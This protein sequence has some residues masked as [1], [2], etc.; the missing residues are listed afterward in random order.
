MARN[1]IGLVGGG[2]I[3]GILALLAGGCSEGG[4]TV[5]MVSGEPLWS[6]PLDLFYV[7]PDISGDGEVNLADI[8][9]FTQALDDYDPCADFNHDGEVNLVDI[10]IMVPAIGADCP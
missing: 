5:V 7:S 10:V 6:T 1:K 2:Q 4:S 9:M 3:G 8:V